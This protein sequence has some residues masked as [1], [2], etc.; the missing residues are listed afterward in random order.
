MDASRDNENGRERL[1]P[2]LVRIDPDGGSQSPPQLQGIGAY[3]ATQR[4]LRGISLTDVC[5]QTHIP[6]RSLERLEAGAFDTIDDGFVRGF[7]RTVAIALGLDLDDTLSRMSREPQ[8]PHE[9]PRAFAGRG[10]VRI[11]VLVVAL[12]LLLISV[13]L[14]GWVVHLVPGQKDVSPLVMRRDPVRALAEARGASSF[15]AAQALVPPAAQNATV[16]SEPSD[17]PQLPTGGSGGTPIGETQSADARSA[18]P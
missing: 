10:L 6:L 12:S 13:G 7:V 5:S 8:T 4:R 9:A 17:S 11:G 15:N 1:D 3:L 2:D 16:A 18:E 14:V